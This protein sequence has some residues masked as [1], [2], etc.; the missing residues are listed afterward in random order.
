[1]TD[2]LPRAVSPADRLYLR[3]RI[4]PDGKIAPEL[5]LIARHGD[6]VVEYAAASVEALCRWAE[7]QGPAVAERLLRLADGCRRARPPV[8]GIALDRPLIMGVVNVTPDSFS[9]GGGAATAAAAIARGRA[10][11]AEGADIIDIGG[12]STRPGAAEVAED[13][14]LARVL[15]VIEGLAGCA[16]PISIDTRKARVMRQAVAAGA[17][18]INDVSALSHDGEAMAV[19][20][21]SGA[22]VVLMHGRGDPA[23]MQQRAEYDDVALD[24]F[25]YLEA[26]IAACA[27]AGIPASRLI[28]DPGIGFG[29]TA[30]HNLELLRGLAVFRA[31]GC[32]VLLGASRKSFIGKLTGVAE[33]GARLPGSLAAA[34]WGLA[35]GADI[36]RV[37][38]AAET[39]QAVALWRAMAGH[40]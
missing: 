6:G 18:I 1:M 25:D 4:G 32:P 19:A 16:R 11:A 27:A 17:A 35:Q 38:D 29:K 22:A 5:A 34:L 12:E 13:E 23:S 37:H 14:E 8:A 33:P 9:D 36:L 39:V 2:R 3:P 15:P 20:A 24:V 26:R 30:D 7:A 28:V 31:L 21:G 40:G 10:L